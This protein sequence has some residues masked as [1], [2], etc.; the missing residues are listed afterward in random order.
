MTTLSGK[1][2]MAR[3]KQ[4]VA[5]SQLTSVSPRAPLEL[6][7]AAS[8]VSTVAAFRFGITDNHQNL[9]VEHGHTC[10]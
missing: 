4:A 8:R 1:P 9:R 5:D 3:W 6:S 7:M 2:I 10:N